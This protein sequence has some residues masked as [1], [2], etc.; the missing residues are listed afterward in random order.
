MIE[1]LA[2]V[3]EIGTDHVTV[4]SEVKSTCSSCQQVNSCA[5]GQVARAIPQKKLIVKLETSLS[6]N[7][8]DK[9]VI[10]IVEKALLSTAIQAYLWPLV[11]LI[12]FSGVGQYFHSQAIFSH[13]LY[14]L[15]FGILGGVLGFW[16]AKVQL[17]KQARQNNLIPKLL[18]KACENR[19]E[20]QLI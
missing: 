1:E 5:S 12:A 2:V 6:L 10:G 18:R 16:V 7:I 20:T 11:G 4:E 17:A 13:E 15:A 8:G 14:A 9:V 3:T 19:I